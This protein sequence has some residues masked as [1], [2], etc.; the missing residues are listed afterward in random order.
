VRDAT[1]M[2]LRAEGYRVLAVATLAEALQQ[3]QVNRSID[4]LVTDQHLAD[5]ATGPQVISVLRER[6][7]APVKAVLITGEGSEGVARPPGD[8]HLRITSKAARAE[9][10]LALLRALLA[11]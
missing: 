2:L 3:A 6:L 9:E 8:P 11:A 10:F 5:G 1:R 4:L 7:G